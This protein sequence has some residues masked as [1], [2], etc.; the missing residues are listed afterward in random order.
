MRA[1]VLCMCICLRCVDKQKKQ[2]VRV[3]IRETVIPSECTNTKC[4]PVRARAVRSPCTGQCTRA[5]TRV[6]AHACNVHRRG[7]CGGGAFNGRAA[8]RADLAPAPHPRPQFG[9]D[10]GAAARVWPP[11]T[12]RVALILRHCAYAPN[13]S[14]IVAVAARFATC[15]SLHLFDR[16]NTGS[17]GLDI[18]LLLDKSVS[19]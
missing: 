7:R 5:A 12:L 17:T 4:A 18:A 15:L 10:R 11:G 6:G 19:M 13:K 3:I 2:R 8:L 16:L 9:C 14:V 1:Y